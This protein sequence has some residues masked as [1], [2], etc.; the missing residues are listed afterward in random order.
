MKVAL[1]TDTYHP[2]VNGVVGSIDTIVSEVGREHEV[3]IYAPTGVKE[4]YRFSSFPF[5]FYPDYR[6]A[7]VRIRTL[8]K[9]FKKEGMDLVHVHTPFSLGLVGIGAGRKLSLPVV[10]TFHTLFPR[11]A[12]YL[13]ETL[14]F[15]LERIA[16]KYSTSFYGRCNLTTVPSVP[17]RDSL[18]DAGL[19]R[20]QV[21]PNAVDTDIFSPGGSEGGKR[22]R[23][24][25]VG[26]LAK[27]KRLGVLIDAAPM[28]LSE[29]PE[30]EFEIVGTGIREDSYRSRVESEGLGENFNFERY[31]ELEDL[32]GAYRRCD[33]FVM[34]SDTETQGLVALEAM[35]CGKP[36]V[37]AD[38]FGLKDVITHDVDGYLF[39]PGSS[40][41]LAGRVLE[42]FLDGRL[43][44]EMG[45]R[46][47]RKA[48]KFSS[49]KI[50]EKWIKLYSSLLGE[51]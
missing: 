12:H 40:K 23:V 5:P 41:E 20:V 34:P 1:V 37:G 7:F 3:Y 43:R 36:V 13:S 4:A 47:R 51:C 30:A 29:Y 48:M 31:L 49:K 19:E 22:P 9:A 21:V 6:I 35:A 11:Y 42:L 50:G 26:R 14:G 10:G 33:V 25:F 39:R 18:L 17:I 16:W 24:L 28:I 32:I 38:A 44:K 45:K 27:E 46:A 8:A 15:L 2:Q